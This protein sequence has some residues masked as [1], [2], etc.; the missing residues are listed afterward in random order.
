MLNT[1]NTVASIC[2]LFSRCVSL[3]FD[4]QMFKILML[5]FSSHS[6]ADRLILCLFFCGSTNIKRIKCKAPLYLIL[7]STRIHFSEVQE[8]AGQSAGGGHPSP[9]VL[10][11]RT[12]VNTNTCQPEEGN[13]RGKCSP[14]SETRW[15]HLF[16]SRFC[17]CS[18]PQ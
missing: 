5:S 1:Q 12:R 10:G 11:G 15:K 13:K 8:A 7:I 6:D 9:G 14:A 3:S 18:V 16:Q 17:I 4:F 2:N